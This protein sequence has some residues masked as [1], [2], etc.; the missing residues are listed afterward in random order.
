M[1]DAFLALS[2]GALRV[3]P[4]VLLLPLAR[5]A[6]SLPM[7][8]SLAFVLT[9]GLGVTSAPVTPVWWPLAAARELAVGV[10]LAVVLAAPFMALEQSVPV[11]SDGASSDALGR[12]VQAASAAVFVAVRGH[13]GALRVLAASWRA[14]PV[15]APWRDALAASSAIEATG[16]ALAGAVV[17]AAAA[18]SARTLTLLFAALAGRLAQG[19]AVDDGATRSL[20]VIAATA[21]G[22]RVAVEVTLDLARRTW[23]L[24]GGG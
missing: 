7:R 10:S 3:L 20:A 17:I 8:V 21:L 23:A 4:S 18:L 12:T 15:G 1:F 2:L 13:H 22:L 24:A 16:S 19:R 14:V 5:G 6:W 11:V 9:L